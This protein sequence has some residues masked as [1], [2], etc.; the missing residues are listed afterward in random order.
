MDV[1]DNSPASTSLDADEYFPYVGAVSVTHILAY[2]WRRH[3]MKKKHVTKMRF[4][5][6]AVIPIGII[7]DTQTRLSDGCSGLFLS[8]RVCH[9]LYKTE[10]SSACG[11][12]LSFWYVLCSSGVLAAR[13]IQSLVAPSKWTLDHS[14]HDDYA[15]NFLL[16]DLVINSGTKPDVNNVARGSDQQRSLD[17]FSQG[18]ID[19]SR[20]FPRS[21]LQADTIIMSYG[22]TNFERISWSRRF[23]YSTRAAEPDARG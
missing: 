10:V 16:D 18:M 11:Y 8:Q 14:M 1:S 7:P 4:I 22:L 12:E 13:W 17:C 3:L 6:L 19:G 5:V 9:A 15:G 20:I 21:V 2:S 23:T